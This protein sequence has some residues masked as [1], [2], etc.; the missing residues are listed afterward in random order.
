[1]SKIYV[2]QAKD[3][4]ELVKKVNEFTKDIFAT[5][6][7]QKSDGSWVAFVYYNDI[8]NK[9]E[10]IDES[11]S[12]QTREGFKPATQKQKDYLKKLGYQENLEKLTKLKAMEE[13]DRM[14]RINNIQDY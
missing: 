13:I 12:I 14:K 9:Q 8:P 4:F 11:G 1:M 5:Q 3:E 6:P 10:K 7:I 2:I